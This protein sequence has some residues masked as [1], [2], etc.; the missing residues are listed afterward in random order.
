MALG[1]HGRYIGVSW[2]PYRQPLILIRAYLAVS[3]QSLH[4]FDPP[5]SIPPHLTS[6]TPPPPA[7][8]L[9]STLYNLTPPVFQLGGKSV[10]N[11]PQI[12]SFLLG[13]VISCA[14]LLADFNG[15]AVK[16]SYSKHQHIFTLKTQSK[17]RVAQLSGRSNLI[18]IKHRWSHLRRK[19]ITIYLKCDRYIYT[20]MSLGFIYTSSFMTPRVISG[21]E[22]VYIYF[23]DSLCLGDLWQMWRF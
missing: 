20:V 13:D 1:H 4:N 7:G 5:P 11:H 17:T 16:A 18:N 15:T 22:L 8:L 12:L 23:L 6:P 19:K 10:A 14:T 3:S 2:D 9:M 21:A